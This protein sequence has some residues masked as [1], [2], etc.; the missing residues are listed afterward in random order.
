MGAKP[1]APA[2]SPSAPPP[3]GTWP[4]CGGVDAYNRPF[5]QCPSQY[6]QR[7]CVGFTSDVNGKLLNN[8]VEKFTNDIKSNNIEKFTNERSK[9]EKFG[10]NKKEKFLT[11]TN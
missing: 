8:N 2:P 7:C 4:Q 11:V 9:S 3:S 5:R 6:G 10:F 1:S